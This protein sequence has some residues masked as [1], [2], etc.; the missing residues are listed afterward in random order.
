MKNLEKNFSSKVVPAGLDFI[1]AKSTTI[2]AMHIS[3]ASCKI[4]SIKNYCRWIHTTTTVAIFIS[5][6]QWH[7]LASSYLTNKPVI[8]SEYNI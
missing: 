2:V 6:C 8:N 1:V 5:S 3:N 4:K 7:D